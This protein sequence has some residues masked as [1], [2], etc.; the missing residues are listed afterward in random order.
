[1]A[2]YTLDCFSACLSQLGSKYERCNVYAAGL[3]WCYT[4]HQLWHLYSASTGPKKR[5]TDS[6]REQSGA[7]REKEMAVEGTT[8]KEKSGV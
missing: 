7:E 4:R 5:G 8:V 1:M 3:L 2:V 6:G